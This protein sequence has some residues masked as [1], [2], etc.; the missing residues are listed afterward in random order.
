MSKNRIIALVVGALALLLGLYLAIAFVVARKHVAGRERWRGQLLQV[1]ALGDAAK[2]SL[3]AAADLA[4][5]DE[6]CRAALP[7]KGHRAVIGYVVPPE[8]PPGADRFGGEVVA[9]QPI[10]GSLSTDFMHNAED[11]VDF[12][13]AFSD[14]LDVF[15]WDN[16]EAGVDLEGSSYLAITVVTGLR[17][18]RLAEDDKTYTPGAGEVKTRVVSW[19]DGKTLC[20]GR[21]APHTPEKLEARGYGKT[22]AGAEASA[23]LSLMRSLDWS[24]R[25]SIVFGPLVAICTAG[26]ERYCERVR[27]EATTE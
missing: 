15:T 4:P 26:D 2:P 21:T 11:P 22:K 3:L 18:P 7:A 13:F 25:Q 12:G 24:F 23:A 8:L 27:R 9:Y 5:L 1:K 20:E 16:E 10:S 6:A 14:A 19:P 17:F